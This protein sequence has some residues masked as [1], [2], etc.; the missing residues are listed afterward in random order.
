MGHKATKAEVELRQRE[1]YKLLCNHATQSEI[2]E[3][4]ELKW[5]IRKKMALEYLKRVRERVREDWELDR[6]QFMADLLTQYAALAK[7]AKASG[8]DNITLGCL[9]QM[10]RLT[11]LVD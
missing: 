11:K 3:Y 8:H 5:G 1:I 4:A 2:V 7:K 10:A 6:R 9:N